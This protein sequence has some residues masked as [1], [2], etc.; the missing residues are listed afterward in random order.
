MAKTLTCINCGKE[1]TVEGTYDLP[2]HWVVSEDVYEQENGTW[3]TVEG[4]SYCSLE[5]YLEWE[6]RY[7]TRKRENNDD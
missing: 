6:T 1:T 4:P 3:E 7:E 2:I 5:C